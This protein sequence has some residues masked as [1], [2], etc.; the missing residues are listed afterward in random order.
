MRQEKGG[1]FEEAGGAL[2]LQI[3]FAFASLNSIVPKV[4]LAIFT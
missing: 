2:V 4:P 3:H 1:F